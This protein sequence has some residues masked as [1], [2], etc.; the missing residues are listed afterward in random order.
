MREWGPPSMG[1]AGIPVQ[2]IPKARGDWI[3]YDKRVFSHSCISPI[4]VVRLSNGFRIAGVHLLFNGVMPHPNYFGGVPPTPCPGGF[5][6]PEP[7]DMWGGTPLPWTGEGRGPSFFPA[8]QPSLRMDLRRRCQ[9]L[10]LLIQAENGGV[11]P[12]PPWGYPPPSPS[13]KQRVPFPPSLGGH[14]HPPPP[15]GYPPT[16]LR[17]GVPPIIGGRRGT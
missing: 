1:C 15:W 4:L 5:P 16:K 7:Q 11:P 13:S 17:V 2:G 10:I 8:P 14:P 3:L 12:L 9:K 6:H